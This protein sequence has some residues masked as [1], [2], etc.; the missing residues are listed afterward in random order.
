V[1]I[2]RMSYVRTP[3]SSPDAH[4]VRPAFFTPGASHGDEELIEREEF[5]PPLVKSPTQ[6]HLFAV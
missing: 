6:L 2:I 1:T 3:F 5:L 4:L